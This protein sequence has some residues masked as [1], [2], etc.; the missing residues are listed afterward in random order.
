LAAVAVTSTAF[1]QV[2]ISGRLDLGTGSTK[3]TTYEEGEFAGRT[4]SSTFAGARNNYTGA[5]IT[6]S[7][8]EDLGGGLKAG[9]NLETA[10][11]ATPLAGWGGR[12]AFLT[13]S[14]DSLGTVIA[15]RYLNSFTGV[16]DQ[17][18]AVWSA[19]GGDFLNEHVA[20]AGGAGTRGANALGWTSPKMGNLTFTLGVSSDSAREQDADRDVT[21]Q[22]KTRGQLFSVAYASGPLTGRVVMASGKQTTGAAGAE[23]MGKVAHTGFIA[24]YDF[25]VAQ[26]YFMTEAARATQTM[27]AGEALD[28]TYGKT[29]A[30]EI[31][32]KVPMGKMVPFVT[33]GRG[34]VMGAEDAETTGNLRTSAWQV[35]A[36]YN[37]SKR[38]YA[39][40]GYGA[41]SVRSNDQELSTESSKVKGYAAGLVHNF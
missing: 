15:G 36:N 33:L 38:T 20:V 3:N 29:R 31:G 2:T 21:D 25:G 30:S 40:F 6:F 17:S 11:N 14:S 27:D 26:A 37:L 10:S 8:T 19:P 35:G 22:A 41:T 13:L 4:E 5:R 32:V 7:G 28:G 9:F 1:A 39:Y 18:Y 24:S 12:N 23:D 16:R 34:K